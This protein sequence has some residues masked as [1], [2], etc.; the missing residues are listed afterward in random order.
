MDSNGARTWQHADVVV[1]GAGLSG[2]VSAAEAYNAGRTVL[3]L[4]QEPEASLGG[5]AHWSFGGLF[6]VDSP[7]SA[8]WA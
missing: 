5:Q 8:A 6:L 4:D 1:V 3:I 2:L 7:N